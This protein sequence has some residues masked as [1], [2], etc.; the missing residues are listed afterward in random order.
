MTRLW[1][2]PG[3][4]CGAGVRRA[5]RR[6]TLY[7]RVAMGFSCD[8]AAA[9]RRVATRADEE[10]RSLRNTLQVLEVNPEKVLRQNG[11]RAATFRSRTPAPTVTQLHHFDAVMK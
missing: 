11:F 3:A 9:E 5:L 6:R 1:R 8:R 7:V 2:L 10:T 4:G